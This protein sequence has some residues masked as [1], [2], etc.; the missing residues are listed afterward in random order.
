MSKRQQPT[1]KNSPSKK[2][3]GN[4]NNNSSNSSMSR[5]LKKGNARR[6]GGGAQTQVSVAANYA[7]GQSGKAPMIK[8]TRDS[9][10]IVHR[11]LLSNVSA[12]AD[13]NFDLFASFALNPGLS[14][15]FPWLASQAQNW[16]TYRFKKLRFCYYTRTGSTTVGSVVFVPDYDAADPA[17][18]NEQ[19]ASTF[20]DVRE[21]APWKDITIP[22]RTA[23]MHQ[24]GMRK[25][26]RTGALAANLDIKTY[27][28]G[29]LF[30]FTVDS[31]AANPWGKLWVEY[32][33]DLFTPQSLSST[34]V[35][36][37]GGTL[38]GGGAQS[39]A[40]PIGTTPTLSGLSSFLTVSSGTLTFQKT[41]QYI[42]GYK[43][44]GSVMSALV[45]SGTATPSSSQTTFDAGA[46][47]FT[48]YVV[49]TVT[50]PG[51]NWTPNLTATT[52]TAFE[53][54]VGMM[55]EGS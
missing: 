45:Q 13:S 36:I 15:T 7:T 35:G 22:L 32:D 16:E 21:D 17:P 34:P 33:V 8:A 29:N 49:L 23:E 44:A 26:I 18:A 1:R 37:S 9:C 3:G 31:T 50:A 20:Q 30:I 24:P 4:S 5:P 19:I 51:Q 47:T 42:V 46:D 43:G 54:H 39:G 27:D 53:A 48:G 6:S 2:K 11:E 28:S 55:P 38:S 12:T 14:A 41:G 40:N 25:Y 10:N 52:V